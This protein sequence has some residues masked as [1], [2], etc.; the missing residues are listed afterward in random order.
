MKE[1]EQ[2]RCSEVLPGRDA[3][4]GVTMATGEERMPP[5]KMSFTFKGKSGGP[6]GSLW[7]KGGERPVFC[8]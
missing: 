3:G 4:T 7:G 6:K 5:G 8:A 2:P 1:V